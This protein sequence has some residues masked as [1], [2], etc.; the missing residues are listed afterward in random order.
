M[1]GRRALAIAGRPNEELDS[2]PMMEAPKLRAELFNSPAKNRGPRVPGVS[3]LTPARKK[4][5]PKPRAETDEEGEFKALG[6]A[7]GKAKVWDSDSEDEDEDFLEGMSPPKTMQFHIPQSKL[8]RTPGMI[9]L[10]FIA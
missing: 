4:N 8:L 7:M 6:K 9:L 1:T 3:V 5:V 10:V 2:S